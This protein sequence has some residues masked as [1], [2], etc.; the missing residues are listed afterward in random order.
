[1]GYLIVF[2]LIL[3][4]ILFSISK[5]DMKT[6]II[7][8]N[9]LRMFALSGI[10]YLICFSLS[11]ENIYI[12]DLII[13]NSFYMLIIFIILYF[14]SFISSKIFRIKSLGMGD[15]KFSSIS[16]I[17]LG[18][19]LCLIS[20]FISFFISAIYSLHGKIFKSLN[21]FQQYPF[22]PFLSIGIF[23][24]WILDKI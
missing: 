2:S 18:I 21:P 4:Y 19:D 1:M 5:E 6:M 14:I 8:E 12:L 10:F 7:S 17:W 20:L 23:F 3:I 22:A 11:N 9:K 16:A 15:I 24:S 13:N